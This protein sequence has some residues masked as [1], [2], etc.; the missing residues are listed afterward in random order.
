MLMR[1]C[2]AGLL[3]GGAARGAAFLVA[4]STL[5]NRVMLRLVSPFLP[6]SLRPKIRLLR[7]LE[8]LRHALRP[9]HDQPE[10]DAAFSRLGHAH[11]DADHDTDGKER[12]LGI[13]LPHFAGGA[14]AHDIPRRADGTLDLPRM[15]LDLRRAAD[16]HRRSRRA[17]RQ[18]Y[19]QPQPP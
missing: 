12:G 1:G 3:K 4:P 10:D 11:D 19:V 7:S 15:I 5:V 2:V 16:D 14:A 17:R 13:D 18:R 6:D 8:D 9:P